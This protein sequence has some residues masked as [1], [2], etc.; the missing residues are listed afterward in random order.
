MGE[1]ERVKQGLEKAMCFL[2]SEGYNVVYLALY[3]SQN[4][5]MAHATSD[6]DF[7]AVVVP[8]LSD[9]VR[10][11]KQVSKQIEFDGGLIDVKDLRL[12]MSTLLKCNPAYL[13][14]MYTQYYLCSTTYSEF[15]K[16]IRG[17]MPDVVREKGDR[18]MSACYGMMSEKHHAL[19]HLYPSQAEEV[20]KYGYAK[21]Q[22]HHLGRLMKLMYDFLE[23]G[24][25]ILVPNT[26][27]NLMGLKVN[28][29]PVDEVHSFAQTMMESAAAMRVEYSK[30]SKPKRTPVSDSVMELSYAVL[31]DAISQECL[32]RILGPE[33]EDGRMFE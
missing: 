22:Y 25:F 31:E 29:R 17:K 18:F 16:E 2:K 9:L 11:T 19:S 14:T 28:T 32:D 23:T 12:F 1:K 13:E 26:R 5:Q 8:N 33:L 4:Y 7:K 24:E 21:K 27:K 10:N 30:T 15:F 6:L 3:G 20:E